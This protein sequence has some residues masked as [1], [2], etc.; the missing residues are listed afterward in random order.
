M[1]RRS[2][3]ASDAGPGDWGTAVEVVPETAALARE[4]LAALGFS[5]RCEVLTGDLRDGERLLPPG[6]RYD[7]IVSNPPYVTAE[8]MEGLA[9]EVLREPRIALTDGGDGLSLI[10][11]IIEEYP[12]RLKP[13]GVLLI[14]HGWRQAESVRAIAEAAGLT[15]AF[16]RDYGGRIRAA[17]MRAQ[18]RPE[19]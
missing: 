6:E 13:G 2:R 12:D 9:P 10:R 17:E 19:E 4:N 7:V 3:P 11:A 8:E 1:H 14:E 18:K 16:L 15:Y 5:D